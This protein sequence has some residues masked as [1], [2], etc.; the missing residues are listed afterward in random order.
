MKTRAAISTLLA[1]AVVATGA[2][3]GDSEAGNSEEAR[4]AQRSSDSS[5]QSLP[6]GAEP[7][8]LDPADFTAQITNR[9]WPMKPGSRW[10]Y[11]ETDTTGEELLVVVTATNET[12]KIANGITARVVRDTVTED[13]HL[14]ED[15]F[16]WY[17]QDTE[18]N[19]WYLGE[20]T[21]EFEDGEIASREGSFE[22]GVDG[23]LAGIIMP[24][25]PQPGQAYRQEYYAGEA[26]DNGEVIALDQQVQ[27]PVGRYKGALM[28]RDT[29]GI[30]PAVNEYKLYA[31][32][33]GL[34]LAVGA[35]GGPLSFE[36][37]IR[38]D[39]A[40]AQFVERAGTAP[41]GEGPL[42]PS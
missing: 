21:A 22:A 31:P 1:T 24:A 9:Y 20:N 35:S 12:K 25:D 27:T 42:L 8:N 4:A 13:G 40:P 29:N 37:L 32:G 30:E 19:V 17:A 34:V 41:L 23:A 28:T 11:R 38:M 7:V 10:V 14:V 3:C 6:Q 2:G 39:T 33:V 16:D 26:E 18:G 15:T 5:G 36:E